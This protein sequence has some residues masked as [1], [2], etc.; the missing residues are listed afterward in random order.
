ME[1]EETFIVSG[2]LD[3]GGPDWAFRT[4]TRFYENGDHEELPGMNI[5]RWNHACSSYINDNN[6]IVSK[7][8]GF[9]SMVAS[10]YFRLSW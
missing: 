8:L 7:T 6:K 10:V 4:V 9:V 5:R 1:V 2:G 3:V